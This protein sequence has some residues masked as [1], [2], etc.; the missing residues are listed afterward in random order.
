[1]PPPS[2]RSLVVSPQSAKARP[3]QPPA[4]HSRTKP[5]PSPATLPRPPSPRLPSPVPPLT[6]RHLISRHDAV[7]GGAA[8]CPSPRAAR[9][10]RVR[11]AA[12]ANELAP[13]RRFTSYN[14]TPPSGRIDRDGAC[15]MLVRWKMLRRGQRA[16]FL[17]YSCSYCGA[18]AGRAAYVAGPRVFCV[19]TILGFRSQ[20]KQ[21]SERTE[22]GR[23][24]SDLSSSSREVCLAY[25][26]RVL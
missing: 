14:A 23:R 10:R 11:L 8:S 12:R 7:G 21:P 6:P 2:H 15:A 9:A 19:Q 22:S 4:R 17:R 16:A 20:R 5:W 18:R 3:G 13:G 1:M 24:Q 26:S 25:A